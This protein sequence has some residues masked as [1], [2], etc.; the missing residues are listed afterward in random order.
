MYCKARIWDIHDLNKPC[1]NPI[2]HN[3]LYCKLHSKVINKYCKK[4]DIIHEYKWQKCGNIDS[5]IPKC[6]TIK[7]H[8]S[9][10][11]KKLKIVEIHHIEE[12]T[13]SQLQ[14]KPK[15]IKKKLKIINQN[16]IPSQL[17][18]IPFK[19]P[20]KEM[21]PF[22]E[23]SKEMT[24]FKEPSK[25]NIAIKEVSN[26]MEPFKE[27][28]K[29]MPPFKE[30]SRVMISIKEV[31]N[32]M[33]PS[34]EMT[35]FKETS[36]E[37][38]PFKEPSKVNIAIKEVSNHMEP[39]KE[40]SKEMTPFK[41][42]SRI[43]IPIKE[44]SNNTK[45]S[46]VNIA[47]KELSNNIKPFKEP[48]KEMIS[49]TGTSKDI[50]V[51]KEVNHTIPD[52][53]ELIEDTND[54]VELNKPYYDIKTRTLLVIPIEYEENIYLLDTKTNYI[55]DLDDNNWIGI[56]DTCGEIINFI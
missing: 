55:Y 45:T 38:T 6:Y 5:D 28:S 17:D 1:N 31:S 15:K 10:N 41:E 47:I 12:T 16:Q 34:K 2:E 46:K 43:M 26:H 49:V 24:P 50:I 53:K 27:L 9:V 13:K 3:S 18:I 22:K 11:K 37:M 30:P 42:P 51:L 7:Y 14:N 36:K 52:T 48:S 54:I 56:Y 29:E 19:E 21:T 4:C 44:V 32:H 23:Q 40:L 39:F 35:P 20:S 25:V 8:A 33:T